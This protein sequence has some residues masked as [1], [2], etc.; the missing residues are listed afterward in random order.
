ML[1]AVV[2]IVILGVGIPAFFSGLVW[3][4]C[5]LSKAK[6]SV[7]GALIVFVPGALTSF[8]FWGHAGPVPALM[9]L[10]TKGDGRYLPWA[11][12]MFGSGLC[13]VVLFGWLSYRRSRVHSALQSVRA[14]AGVS[15]SVSQGGSR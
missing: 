1:F 13:V 5:G 15:S 11:L 9:M 3:Y 2:V 6:L 4:F 8:I 10:L 14:S 7:R 12:W